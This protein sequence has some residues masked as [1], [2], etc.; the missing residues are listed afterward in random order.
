MQGLVQGTGLGHQLV[1]SLAQQLGARVEI[2]SD[3]QGTVISLTF[4]AD[5]QLNVAPKLEAGTIMRAGT[6]SSQLGAGF[7]QPSA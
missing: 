4:D 7:A 5:K 3:G 2:K 6:S 1:R